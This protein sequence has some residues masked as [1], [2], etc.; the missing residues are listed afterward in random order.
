MK[1]SAKQHPIPIAR[2][3]GRGIDRRIALITSNALVRTISS[4]CV[5]SARPVAL[6]TSQTPYPIAPAIGMKNVASAQYFGD[7]LMDL[8][9]DTAFSQDAGV[10]NGGGVGTGNGGAATGIGGGGGTGTV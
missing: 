8:M 10:G 1:R 2:D 9:I 6:I 5:D 4:D 7:S 3:P